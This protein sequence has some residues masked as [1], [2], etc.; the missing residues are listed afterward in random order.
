MDRLCDMVRFPSHL[1]CSIEVASDLSVSIWLPGQSA[2]LPCAASAGARESSSGV[3]DSGRSRK[4]R[5][6]GQCA[7]PLCE[8]VRRQ[9]PASTGHG[10]N[11][12]RP[13]RFRQRSS[14]TRTEPRRRVRRDSRGGCTDVSSPLAEAKCRKQPCAWIHRLVPLA[15]EHDEILKER[16]AAQY[17]TQWP[18]AAIRADV[19]FRA[20][21]EGAYT[22]LH[23]A[24]SQSRA[25]FRTSRPSVH[26]KRWSTRLPTSSSAG[27][28]EQ[29]ASG[30]AQW[31]SCP[32]EKPCG[33][34]SSS[35]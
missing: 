14:S 35:T 23:P 8:S 16:L 4:R 31:G 17:D 28:E 9:G 7:R 24:E 1:V 15:A 20:N 30:P 2:S 29:S 26:W 32:P 3:L 5:R 21:W 6:L 18:N 22:T 27:F 11:Q 10:G 34:L 19:V 25:G 33:T 13:Q 12:E